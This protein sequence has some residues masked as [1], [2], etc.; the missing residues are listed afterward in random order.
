[1]LVPKGNISFPHI[2]SAV[3]YYTMKGMWLDVFFSQKEKCPCVQHY[4]ANRKI[5]F[6]IYSVAELTN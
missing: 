4:V 3:F 5:Q 6:R 2:I 1:M